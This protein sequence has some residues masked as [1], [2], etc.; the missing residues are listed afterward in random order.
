MSGQKPKFGSQHLGGE[1]SCWRWETF[2]NQGLAV[3]GVREEEG[4]I[5]TGSYLDE[6]TFGRSFEC[7][8]N[9][10][11]Q[12]GQGKIYFQLESVSNHL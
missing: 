1:L 5:L 6:M 9:L 2:K 7:S 12:R 4:T 10:D 11:E 3:V 8:E